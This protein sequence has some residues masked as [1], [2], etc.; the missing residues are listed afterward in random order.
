MGGRGGE[1]GGSRRGEQEE[2]EKHIERNLAT[3]P[4][5]VDKNKQQPSNNKQRL[6][7]Q[8][9]PPTTNRPT[10]Q[11]PTD[12]RTNRPTRKRMS[13]QTQERCWMKDSWR[14]QEQKRSSS[15]EKKYMQL[16][17]MQPAFTVWWRNG[18][19]VKNSSRSPKKMD[20]CGQEKRGNKASNGVVCC[21]QQV[22]M[23]EVW[24][25]QQVQENAW[26]MHKA[27]VLVE[28]LVKMEKATYGKDATW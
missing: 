17:S 24:K 19:T 10:D 22:S 20:P 4:E 21:C 16:C 3:P 11:Q 5:G 6:Q 26:K 13:W 15:K 8:P 14:R 12:H 1:E 9:Q 2:E 27:E 25:R 28:E 7:P 23:H 18:R